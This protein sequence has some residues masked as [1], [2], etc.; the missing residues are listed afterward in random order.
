[1]QNIFQPFQF[2][3]LHQDLMTH[4]RDRHYFGDHW[5]ADF[6]RN[7]RAGARVIVST[8]FPV[9]D[10]EDWF[11]PIV[12]DMIERDFLDYVTQCSQDDRFELITGRSDIE[13]V[14]K[15]E[16]NGILMHIEGLNVFEG[17][18]EEWRRL[19]KWYDLGWRSLGIVW[20][21]SNHLGGG[22]LDVDKTLTPLGIRMLNWLQER[23]M[24][25]DLAHMNRPTF[26]ASVPHI[27][28]P[29]YISHGN[30]SACCES[31]RNYSD[32]QLRIVSSSGG[33]C[34]V[35]FAKSYVT[36]KQ[37]K[38]ATID[39]VCEHIDHMRNIM[40]IDHIALGTDFG[41]IIS[42]FVDELDHVETL[43]RLFSA[44]ASRGYSQESCEKIAWRNAERVLKDIL[45]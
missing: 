13:H 36:G 32:D 40:G 25:V 2:I 15:E 41:G 8:A 37:S 43:P 4:I 24:I 35:F 26:D 20:N 39:D 22:T 10:N 9:P 14:F 7:V 23:N 30:C 16:K 11:D 42:G 29:L 38:R 5:Q 19:E 33:V 27:S 45:Q 6:D 44:L 28:H 21:Y 18:E 31:P 1:M 3:D 12:N 34:G 17:R